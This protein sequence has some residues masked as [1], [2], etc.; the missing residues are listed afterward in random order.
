MPSLGQEML[1]L[2]RGEPF[3]GASGL[4]QLKPN[5]DRL[6]VFDVLSVQ[7]GEYEV[8]GNWREDTRLMERGC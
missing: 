4:V 8:V 7:R 3:E 5:G 6:A 1:N 2:I